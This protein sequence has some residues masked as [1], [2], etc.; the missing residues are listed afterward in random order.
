MSLQQKFEHFVRE[1]QLCNTEETMLIAISGGVDSVVLAHLWR[2]S[3]RPMALA[4]CNFGL[5][6]EASDG[7]EAF[8]R[9]LAAAWDVPILVRRFDT[10]CFAAEAGISTQMAARDLRYGWFADLLYEGDYAG[11]ATGHHLQDSLETA[12]LHWTRGT[13]LNGLTG[14]PLRNG[15]IIRPLLCATRQD[16]LQ[17][18]QENRLS[19]R[20]DA[21]NTED[22]YTRN[23]LRLH[24]LP[25]LENMNPGFWESAART[26]QI[27]TDTRD[28]YRFL[29]QRF[30]QQTGEYG[31]GVLRFHIP[32]IQCAPAPE[33]L[34]FDL[35]HDCGFN[36]DQIAQLTRHLDVTGFELRSAGGRRVLVD[37][38]NLL[39]TRKD[40]RAMQEPVRI[41]ADDLIVRLPDDSRLVLSPASVEGAFPDGRLE[42]KVDAEKVKFPLLLRHWKNGD[43]FYPFGMGG[44]RQKLQDF[45]T[46][47]KLSRLEKEKTL[48]LENADGA[49]VWAL[50]LRPDER[51]KVD[52]STQSA[53]RIMWMV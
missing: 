2:A 24:V 33:A 31:D 36:A 45:L 16:I 51:F 52:S 17:Y 26:L 38:D 20:E 50:G 39:L 30:A 6:S 15:A 53:L 34:L 25:H 28:N 12:L 10:K 1:E 5:R 18:A 44:R 9:D 4:H 7:D 29:L 35:F 37:R 27:L 13:G 40:L 41:E 23:Y 14:I 47:L 48:V 22:T 21:S 43:V 19:W 42:I 3:G 32:T 49:I 8:V 11:V 46:N